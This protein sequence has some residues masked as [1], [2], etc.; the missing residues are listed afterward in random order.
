MINVTPKT[1]KTQN[2]KRTNS[3]PTIPPP[4][5]PVVVNQKI[6]V[7]SI[8]SSPS[9]PMS[10]S[11]SQSVPSISPIKPVMITGSTMM[12]PSNVRQFANS[13][14]FVFLINLLIYF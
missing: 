4:G 14:N 11:R 2:I 5:S 6:S 7:S 10:V 12:S 8:M 3:A 13:N 1:P 9:S